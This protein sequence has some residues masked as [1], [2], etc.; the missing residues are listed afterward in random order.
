[1]TGGAHE[2]VFHAKAAT[3]V[4][5]LPERAGVAL[6]E[7][8]VAA[9]RE[10]WAETMPDPLMDDPAFRFALFDGGDGVVHVRVS[11]GDRL[12]VVHSVTWIG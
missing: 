7:T 5:G 4:R 9:S 1:V 10:P 6:W 11:D 8:L 12:V 2:V 3:E